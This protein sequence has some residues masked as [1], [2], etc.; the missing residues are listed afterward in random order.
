MQL[1]W[2]SLLHGEGPRGMFTGHRWRGT[3]FNVREIAHLVPVSRFG[4]AGRS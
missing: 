3:T 1:E 4:A 2:V